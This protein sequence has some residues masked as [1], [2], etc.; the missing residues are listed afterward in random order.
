MFT[1]D[2][3]PEVSCGTTGSF[4]HDAPVVSATF[5]PNGRK[6][7][8]VCADWRIAIWDL[9]TKR[10]LASLRVYDFATAAAK[11]AVDIQFGKCG[12]WQSPE[13]MSVAFSVDSKTLFARSAAVEAGTVHLGQWDAATGEALQKFEGDGRFCLSHDGR[14]L[15]TLAR[16]A[17]RVWD[18]ATGKEM[19]AIETPVAAITRLAFLPD[20][21]RLVA[22][23][24]QRTIRVWDLVDRKMS[25]SFDVESRSLWP[26]PHPFLVLSPEGRRVV[27]G[28]SW[29]GTLSLWDGNK[30]KD[31]RRLT[32]TSHLIYGVNFSADGSKL[33]GVIGNQIVLIDIATAKALQRIDLSKWKAGITTVALAP[34]GKNL[35]A[36]GTDGKA[37]LCPVR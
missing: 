24:G 32:V 6:L 31:A 4:S 20:G 18:I 19:S 11:V 17:I 37:T 30:D 23:E 28:G 10:P 7:A 26:Q 14:T 35:V 8:V 25:R 33:V 29:D 27:Q 16:N 21:K 9:A 3:R 36:G 1:A 2:S 12:L 5:A 34:D 13:P 22:S 15:A